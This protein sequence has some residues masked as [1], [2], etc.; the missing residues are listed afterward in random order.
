MPVLDVSRKWNRTLRGLLCPSLT[1]RHDCRP[2]HVV[3][4]VSTSPYRP[5]A[6]MGHVSCTCSCADGQTLGSFLPGGKISTR[7]RLSSPS[8]HLAGEP[9]SPGQSVVPWSLCGHCAGR[10]GNR[11][12]ASH[13]AA[14]SP[15]AVCEGS[16]VSASSPLSPALKMFAFPSLRLLIRSS[17][18]VSGFIC[19]S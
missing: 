7:A 11:Q 4:S 1:E 17:F 5:P 14:A 19:F 3:V 6:C 2:T 13:G 16:E 10:L 12:P 15:S 9:W 18:E 8:L